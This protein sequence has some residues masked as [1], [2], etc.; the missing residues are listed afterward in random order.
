MLLLAPF[1][2]TYV[3]RIQCNKKSE[4]E[5]LTFY[6]EECSDIGVLTLRPCLKQHGKPETNRGRRG[7]RVA[8]SKRRA[9]R[10]RRLPVAK[11]GMLAARARLRRV[12]ACPRSHSSG[13]AR[14]PTG[15]GRAPRGDREGRPTAVLGRS[16]FR[17][18][19]WRR[20]MR[21]GGEAAS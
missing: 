18:A 7:A 19:A 2:F 14:P 11:V 5:I 10:R 15:D 1:F 16:P 3:T 12:R 9:R 6:F 21:F 20:A 13:K 17:V 4:N 8:G